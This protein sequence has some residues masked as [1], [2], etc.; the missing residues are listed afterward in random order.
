MFASVVVA[1]STDSAYVG[2]PGTEK[3]VQMA[4]PGTGKNQ[5]SHRHQLGWEVN[6]SSLTAASCLILFRVLLQSDL[7]TESSMAL[8]KCTLAGNINLC[9]SDAQSQEGVPS[10]IFFCMYGGIHN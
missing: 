10:R 1:F 9:P 3:K 8:K 7:R 5:N 6:A 2:L 4:A